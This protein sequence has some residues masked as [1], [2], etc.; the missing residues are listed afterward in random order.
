MKKV[1]LHYYQQY[2]I[3]PNK[4]TKNPK[5]AEIYCSNDTTIQSN[6][7]HSHVNKSQHPTTTMYFI[8]ADEQTT[9]NNSPGA[10]NF[11]PLH[12]Q[13]KTVYC[14]ENGRHQVEDLAERTQTMSHQ[15]S[16]ST[17]RERKSREEKKRPL[18]ACFSKSCPSMC[19]GVKSSVTQHKKQRKFVVQ[20]VIYLWVDSFFSKSSNIQN[21]KTKKSQ[22][23]IIIIK[24]LI[25]ASGKKR[26]RKRNL[27]K[28]GALKYAC[29]HLPLWYT[30]NKIINN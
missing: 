23:F 10:D 2:L 30:I 12:L 11:M 4:K 19:V 3:N 29:A 13:E 1:N 18:H 14:K 22:Q 16:M 15:I 6:I 21:K 28:K 7:L 8:E 20:Q 5:A 25:Y 24:I 26:K 27:H 9:F 17:C